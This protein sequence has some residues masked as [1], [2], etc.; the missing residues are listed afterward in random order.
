MVRLGFPA[1]QEARRLAYLRELGIDL[2]RPRSASV[3]KPDAN[4]EQSL[5]SWV[6][7]ERSVAACQRCELSDNRTQTV[8]G[9]G[10][11]MAD[12]MIIGEAPGAEEDRQGEPFVGRAG[13]LLNRMLAALGIAREEVFIANMVKCRPPS[14]RNPQPEEIAVCADFLRLQ[15]A[16]VE[17]RA[18]LVLG[19][20]AAQALLESSAPMGKLRGHVHRFQPQSTPL[21][22]TYHPAYLLRT[23]RDKRKSWQDLCLVARILGD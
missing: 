19:L 1:D 11:R 4:A 20:V 7:L 13:Q 21:V 9:F 10:N 17:P 2:Y 16:L 6:Q 12:L 8:F 23:P 14:N 18:I 5:P 3:A 22:A 15:I